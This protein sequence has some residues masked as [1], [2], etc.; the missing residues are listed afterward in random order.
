MTATGENWMTVDTFT[1]HPHPGLTP[2][3][4]E[5]LP[6]GNNQR[7]ERPPAHPR[8]F[9]PLTAPHPGK[10]CHPV[11]GP[12]AAELHRVSVGVLEITPLLA[13]SD[14]FTLQP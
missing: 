2:V 11:V 4:L 12:G 13:P 1:A 14:R 7:N 9:L 8:A 6:G 10:R 3:E 5:R